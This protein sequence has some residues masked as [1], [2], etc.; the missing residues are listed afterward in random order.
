MGLSEVECG[1]DFGIACG[2]G[3]FSEEF[4]SSCSSAESKWPLVMPTQLECILLVVQ[5]LCP[6]YGIP[7]PSSCFGYPTE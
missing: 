5:I 4:A 3:S 6:L 1:L 2:Q 7:E